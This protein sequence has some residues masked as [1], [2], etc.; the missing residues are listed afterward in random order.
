[1]I[2][3]ASNK[4]FS[5]GNPIANLIVVIVGLLTIGAFIVIGVFAAVALSGIVVVMAS[6]LAVRMWWLGRKLP[7]Q[8]RTTNKTRHAHPSDTSVIEGEFQVVS[9]DQDEN[10]PE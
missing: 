4:H 9:A 7:K 1:M 6:I 2:R 8:D 10:R 3:H 5:A